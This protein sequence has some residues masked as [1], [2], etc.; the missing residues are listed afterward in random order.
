MRKVVM[1]NRV[2]IGGF[3]AGPN[4]EIDWFIRDLEVDKALHETG[5]ADTA[6]F[7]RVTYQLF[8]SVW[9][10]VAAD[11]N[12]PKEARSTAHELNDMTKVVFSNTLEKVTWVNSQLVKGNLAQEVRKLKQGNGLAMIIFGNG[13]VVQQ[14]TAEGLIDDYVFLVTPV[15]LGA[16]KPLFEGVKKR[17]L[18]LVETRGFKSGNVLLHYRM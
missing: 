5:A 15:V 12:A 10:K 11:P 9:P 18:E 14:L 2:S 13:T 16:G 6:L 7:G 8:E 1:M 3:F 4:G 17:S